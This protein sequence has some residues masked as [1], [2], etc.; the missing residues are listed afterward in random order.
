MD[1]SYRIQQSHPNSLY[2]IPNAKVVHRGSQ[3]GRIT[4]EYRIQME[5]SY[6]AYF[7]FKNV[8]QTPWNIM[9]FVYGIFG[10]FIISLLSM[11]GKSTFFTVK[12]QFNMLRHIK[13]VRAGNFASFERR[14]FG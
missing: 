10:R 1:I 9:N 2:L 5:I 13:E 8:K 4:A 14:N 3:L 6:H 7:F 12:A 11:N